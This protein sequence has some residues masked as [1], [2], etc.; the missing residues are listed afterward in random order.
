MK[1]AAALIV[2]LILPTASLLFAFGVLAAT[3][4][5]VMPN[6]FAPYEIVGKALIEINSEYD[7]DY[8]NY[9]H[10][11]QSYASWVCQQQPKDGPITHVTAFVENG[12]VTRVSF[13][14]VDLE[15]GYLVGRFN[16][17]DRIINRPG[18][19]YWACWD[20]GIVATGYT[21]GYFNY[22][23]PVSYV[24]FSDETPVLC[25]DKAQ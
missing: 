23:K 25:R 3:P 7:C 6:P 9:E 22:T 14:V 13:R 18:K 2:K 10:S 8:I 12:Y 21:F 11:M 16:R 4:Q 19:S 5:S 1:I 17:P 15:I 20:E 24:M